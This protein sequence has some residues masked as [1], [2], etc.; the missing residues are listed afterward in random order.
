MSLKLTNILRVLNQQQLTSHA[1][2]NGEMD[3]DV[4]MEQPEEFAEGNPRQTVC[5]LQK[6]I[7]GTKQGGNC[8]NKKMR[9]VHEFLG[10]TQSYSDASIY[11]YVKGDTRVILPVFVDDMTF[12]SKSAAAIDQIIL[13]LSQHFKLRDLGHTTQLL[14][15]KIDRDRSKRSITISQ[16]QY[17]LDILEHFGM[18]D[19]KPISTPMQPNSRLSRS[20]CLQ[21]PEEVEFMK[22]IPYLT[23][24]GAL[25]YLATST[26]PDISY[27]VG[28]LARFNSNPGIVHWHAVKHLLRYL[29]GTAD[30]SI[31][32]QD[33]T[34]LPGQHSAPTPDSGTACRSDGLPCGLYGLPALHYMAEGSS[35]LAMLVG[36]VPG[37]T[38]L[39][40]QHSAP[41][42]DSS[43]TCRSDGLPAEQYM[44]ESSS[45]PLI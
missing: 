28:C 17:C 31:T 40:G 32:W 23:A 26:H 34:V 4:Y 43:T 42:P 3:C 16:H 7:Y 19:C 9:A 36:Y 22:G 29:K 21:K 14:C 33:T 6:S 38:V 24:V 35:M 10:F 45:M 15:I 2:L 18:S 5:L 44:A 30:Y 27:T 13:E 25:M 12:A 11:V 41:T 20:Q 1:Y 8:W 39:P 37:A